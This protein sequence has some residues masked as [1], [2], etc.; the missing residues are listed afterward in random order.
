MTAESTSGF[1]TSGL[2]VLDIEL[3][4]LQQLRRTINCDFNYACEL[5]M[6]CEGKVVVTG[7]QGHHQS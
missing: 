4:A 5:L 1:I 3:E 2:K 7:M 6:A